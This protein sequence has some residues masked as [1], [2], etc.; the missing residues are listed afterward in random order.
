MLDFLTVLFGETSSL[1]IEHLQGFKR[2]GVSPVARLLFSLLQLFVVSAAA[3]VTDVFV[4]AAVV[5]CQYLP[6]HSFKHL[7]SS[8]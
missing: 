3:V 1:F 4:P 5:E 7:N 6:Q 2:G 8:I